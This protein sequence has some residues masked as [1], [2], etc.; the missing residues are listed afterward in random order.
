MA[1]AKG[2]TTSTACTVLYTT[3]QCQVCGE[4]GH[5]DS[6]CPKVKAI[7]YYQDG[8]IKRI[9]KFTPNDYM[10]KRNNSSDLK[11]PYIVT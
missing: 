7:Q 1:M 5:F 9:E 10:P 4:F 6:Y 11:P 2:A 3:T 8:T